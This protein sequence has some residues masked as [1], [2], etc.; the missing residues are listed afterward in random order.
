MGNIWNFVAQVARLRILGEIC[1]PDCG[2]P[3]GEESLNGRRCLGC[4]E[5]WPLYKLSEWVA[6][7][8]FDSQ[9]VLNR[10][11]KN[12]RELM[13]G[14][15]DD[16][17]STLEWTLTQLENLTTTEYSAGGDKAIRQRLKETILKA[18]GQV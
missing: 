5:V 11:I 18:R 7:D 12:A 4:G 14:K 1:C 2:E 13:V 8:P 17:L 16:L 10:I 9:E 3:L 6:D 15:H